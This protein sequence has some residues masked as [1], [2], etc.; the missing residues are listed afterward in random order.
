[1]SSLYEF[2]GESTSN[3]NQRSFIMTTTPLHR[4]SEEV[5]HMIANLLDVESLCAFTST[6][7]EFYPLRT[8]NNLLVSL[9]NEDRDH[10]LA[11][12][13]SF[14]VYAQRDRIPC[15]RCV[16]LHRLSRFAYRNPNYNP[17]FD[18]GCD[19]SRMCRTVG[20]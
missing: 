16:A 18:T 12:R 20:S 7:R 3:A 5:Q 14:P 13:E 10:F 4:L 15:Y 2:P 1:M 17:G 9:L 19:G 11:C 6:S 8:Q